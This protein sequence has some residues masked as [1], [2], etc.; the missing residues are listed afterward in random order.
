MQLC[1]GLFPP[2]AVDNLG[3]TL[4][5]GRP[6]AE[7]LGVRRRRGGT[8]EFEHDVVR[9]AVVPVLTWFE[10]SND[11]MSYRPVVSRGVLSG[12]IVTTPDVPAFLTYPQMDP[13]SPPCSQTFQTPRS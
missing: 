9:V 12:R 3:A 11:R 5:C 1:C 8:L 10:R 4:R 6:R 13:V 7:R 2:A